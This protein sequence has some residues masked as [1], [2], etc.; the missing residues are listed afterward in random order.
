M[1]KS[2][3]NLDTGVMVFKWFMQDTCIFHKVINITH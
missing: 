2:K 3:E 1:G